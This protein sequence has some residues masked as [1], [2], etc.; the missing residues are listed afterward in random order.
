MT[1]QAD[2]KKMHPI[3]GLNSSIAARGGAG[4]TTNTNI[5]EREN[6]RN[7]KVRQDMEGF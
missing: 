7:R 5:V 1:D 3:I 6:H 2:L 4:E